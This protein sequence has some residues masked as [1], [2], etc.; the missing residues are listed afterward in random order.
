MVSRSNCSIQELICSF[1]AVNSHKTVYKDNTCMKLG[2]KYETNKVQGKNIFRRMDNP[3]LKDKKRKLAVDNR[4]RKRVVSSGAAQPLPKRCTYTHKC[5]SKN[6]QCKVVINLIMFH[7]TNHWY[8]STVGD[9][10]HKFHAA[11]DEEH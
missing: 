5:R 1:H 2:T 6:T 7:V 8:L 10:H 3:K 4:S 9:L 11:L